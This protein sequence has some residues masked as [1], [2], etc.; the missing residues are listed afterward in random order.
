MFGKSN[1]LT[2]FKNKFYKPVETEEDY[3]VDSNDEIKPLIIAF[4]G[5]SGGIYQPVFEFKN[6]LQKNVDCHFIF[7]KDTNQCWYHKGAIGLG[8]NIENVTQN[9]KNIIKKIN[10]SKVVTI[11]GSMGGF[12]ALLFGIQLNV[13]G[14]I[15]FSPQTF[16]DKDNRKLHDDDRWSKQINYVQKNFNRIYFDLS[17]LVFNN[18]K[19]YSIYG[20]EDRLDKIHSERLKSKGINISCYSGGHNV[21]K[22]IRDNGELIK[23][24][25]DCIF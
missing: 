17:D 15:A 24:I 18:I 10:Y 16:I 19:V 20:K 4:G 25:N 12:A 2:N 3:L 6:F 22:T 7:V 1:F 8:N 13:D 14:I 23:I 9:L 21:V 11:G 5:I